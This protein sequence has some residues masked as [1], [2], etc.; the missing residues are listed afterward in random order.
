VHFGG[1]LPHIWSKEAHGFPTRVPF[2][3]EAPVVH[4]LFAEELQWLIFGRIIQP[5]IMQ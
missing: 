3:V 2:V 5:S 4:N 1:T